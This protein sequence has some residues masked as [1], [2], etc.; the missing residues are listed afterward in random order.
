MFDDELERGEIVPIMQPFWGESIP[1]WLYYSSREFLP[2]R[3]RALID[4]LVANIHKV[5]S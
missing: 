2:T 1:V 5:V 4:F 3:V